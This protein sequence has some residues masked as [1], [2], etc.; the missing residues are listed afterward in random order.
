LSK[1]FLAVPRA[2]PR[3]RYRVEIVISAGDAGSATFSRNV[4]LPR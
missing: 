2:A 4:T 1:A 3:G